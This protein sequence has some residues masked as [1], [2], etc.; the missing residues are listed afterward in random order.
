MCIRDRDI[1]FGTGALTKQL[2]D[3]GFTIFGIDFSDKMVEKAKAKMPGAVLLQHDFAEGLPEVLSS[4]SFDCIL[5]T[6]AIHHLS[7]TL[8]VT[9]IAKLLE[10]LSETGQLLVG[11]VAFSTVKELERC[12]ASDR[13][14]WDEEEFYPCLLYTSPE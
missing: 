14:A 2:Y 6:Y 5:S 4:V 8:K 10:R 3:E 13:G 7:D 12:R 1:G 11:D 9:F